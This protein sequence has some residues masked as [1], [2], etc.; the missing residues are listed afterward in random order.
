MGGKI[1]LSHTCPSCGKLANTAKELL[2]YFGY[3]NMPNN[4]VRNQSHCKECRPK[5]DKC[6]IRSVIKYVGGKAN[7]LR[8]LEEHIPKEYNTYFEPFLGG[9]SLFF[10]LQPEKAILSDINEDLMIMYRVLRDKLPLLIKSLKVHENTKEYYYK[11]RELDR[12]R[13]YYHLSRITRASRFLYL[14]RTCFNGIYRV[15]S[16]NQYNVPYGNYRNPTICNE[17]VLTKASN[18]LQNKTLIHCSFHDIK[19]LVKKNDF[20]YLDSPYV[21]IANNSFTSYGFRDFPMCYH[22][23]LKEWCDEMTKN[24]VKFL[25]SNSNSDIVHDLYSDYTKVKVYANRNINIHKKA[26]GKIAELLIKNY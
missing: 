12:H 3:R 19:D 18:A 1:N 6:R 24:G 8:D 7:L 14:N 26:K 10:K 21:P 11:I 16:N 13:N 5:Y 4:T 22:R 23:E 15:N 17:T 2:D 9:G 20:V 25:M